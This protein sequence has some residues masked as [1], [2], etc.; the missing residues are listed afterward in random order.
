MQLAYVVPKRSKSVSLKS[1]SVIAA[2]T[3]AFIVGGVATGATPSPVVFTVYGATATQSLVVDSNGNGNPDPGDVLSISG[4]LSNS[5]GTGI[6]D[7]K[8]NVFFINSN[9]ASVRARFRFSR[10]ELW[11]KGSFNPSA[12]S[13]PSLQVFAGSGSFGGLYAYGTLAVRDLGAGVNAFTFSLW[14]RPLVWHP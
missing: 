12:G 8:A 5:L 2:C 6:G 1:V 14:Q 13:P 7:W 10:G 11:V 9:T 3:L 4:P